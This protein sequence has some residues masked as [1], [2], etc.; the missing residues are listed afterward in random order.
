MNRPN[1]EFGIFSPAEIQTLSQSIAE[2]VA[3]KISERPTLV[4]RH[5]LARQLQT[6]VATVDRLRRDGKITP[7]YL[8]DS[9]RFDVSE[10]I[11]ELRSAK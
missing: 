1:N 6:S 8:G 2:R 5:E 7:I 10:V 4:D 3:D 9:P 11:R